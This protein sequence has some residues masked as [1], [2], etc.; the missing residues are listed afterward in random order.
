MASV[1]RGLSDEAF[2]EAFGTE[3]RYRSAMV[4]LR[5]PDGSV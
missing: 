4:R 5:C 2:W 1:V 3:E